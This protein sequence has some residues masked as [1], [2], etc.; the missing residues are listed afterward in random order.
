GHLDG[1]RGLTVLVVEDQP[2]NQRIL[3]E[4]VRSWG[5]AAD[6][7]A[8]GETAL[9][10][11]AAAR[12]AGR[13]YALVLLDAQLPAMDGFVVAA[14]IREEPG[15]GGETVVMMLSASGS[16]RESAR[17]RELGAPLCVTK[18]VKPSQ[19]LD[20]ILVA[21]APST[22]EQEIAEAAPFAEPTR[23]PGRRPRILLA[24]D[25]PV[26]RQ[27][28]IAILRRQGIAVQ[29]VVDGAEA[30]AAVAREPF[31]L[32]LMDV[33]M[34]RMDGYEATATIRQA[35][36]GTG[37]HLPIVALTAHA[38]K[39]DRELCMAAGMDAYLSKPIR[40]A[41]LLATIDRLVLP[42]S[43]LPAVPV[44]AHRAFD[45]RA[46]LEAVD[47]DREVQA[48]LV[49]LLCA[50]LPVT[51]ADIRRCLDGGDTNGL[52]RGAHR[53][54][55]SLKVVGADEASRV[56]LA[57]EMAGREG[58]L[59]DVAAR[60]GELEEEISRLERDLADFARSEAAMS[61]GEWPSRLAM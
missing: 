61:R 38:M 42:A 13:P 31:D 28:V 57:V 48:E 12:H 49:E 30:V 40:S 37:R 25:N 45:A 59:A 44:G 39:G 53:L 18:P 27:L 8:D 34:P 43:K 14:R 47:G 24:E 1:L 21:L 32:V 3:E 36:R 60:F 10:A 56:A 54:R 26:N 50:E 51:M 2:T 46:F 16:A 11:V 9:T 4:M 5:F 41:E 17:C 52:Q 55:G 6:C 29:P 7:V 20:I 35:E 22:R 33:Q 23:H 19:L 58:N 15:P